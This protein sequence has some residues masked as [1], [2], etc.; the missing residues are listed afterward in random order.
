MQQVTVRRM[1]FYQFETACQS[2]L[3]RIDKGLYDGVN[4]LG[5]KFFRSLKLRGKRHRARCYRLPL[6][7]S[8]HRF[9]TQPRTLGARL[10]TGVRQLYSRYAVVGGNESCD[11]RK[12]FNVLV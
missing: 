2:A 12:W 9:A 5:G 8:F 1:N 7:R 11:A 6:P 10:A 3:C 4:L